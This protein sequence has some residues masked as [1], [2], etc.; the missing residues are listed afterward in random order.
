MATG[1]KASKRVKAGNSKAAAAD[2]RVKFIEAYIQNGGNGAE[3]AIA[4]GFAANSAKVTASRLLTNANLRKEIERRRSEVIEIAQ[5]KTQLTADEVMA[6][7]A[8]DLRFD[9]AKCY[10]ESGGFKDIHDIDL[11]TRLAL[12]GMEVDQ[13]KSD[14]A[15]I[16]HTVKLKFPEKT[17]AR[18]QGMKHFGLY[19]ENNEQSKS[20]I[21]VAIIQLVALAPSAPSG[22]TIDANG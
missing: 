7:L 5:E 11:D 18:E 15:V 8:R 6:S 17:S 1:K 20:P 19:K 9:P 13:I 16:G 22:E 2:R 12:R 21:Q 4:A 14:G 3:A 10:D